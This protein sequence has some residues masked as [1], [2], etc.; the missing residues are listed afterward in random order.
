M[1]LQVLSDLTLSALGERREAGDR[2][3]VLRPRKVLAADVL[4]KLDEFLLVA[5]EVSQLNREGFGPTEGLERTEAAATSEEPVAGRG[6]RYD[7]GLKL[8]ETG[9]RGGEGRDVSVVAALPIG[10][11]LDRGY[12]DEHDGGPFIDYEFS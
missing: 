4:F 10:K 5:R 8:T 6:L 7:D 11:N 9:D 3:D 2:F 12:G 1:D